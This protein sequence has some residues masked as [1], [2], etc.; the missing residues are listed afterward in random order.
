MAQLVL[1][2][3]QPDHGVQRESLVTTITERWDRCGQKFT[4]TFK[5]APLVGHSAQE[6]PAASNPKS[7]AQPLGLVGRCQKPSIR[8]R[9]PAS[10][11]QQASEL[12]SV[13]YCVYAVAKNACARDIDQ[14]DRN[15]NP[16]RDGGNC[17]TQ[18][19]Q[20][21]IDISQRW[22]VHTRARFR[23]VSL[24]ASVLLKRIRLW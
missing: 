6:L 15:L 1:S 21:D 2:V 20:N 24:Q 23:G 12:E 3:C 10:I 13:S 22:G 9:V 11:G 5:I 18:P 16:G 7:V 4:R 8:V 19:S 14:K 17:A